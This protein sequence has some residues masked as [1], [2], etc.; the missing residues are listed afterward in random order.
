MAE[1]LGSAVLTVSVDDGQLK[2]G[3]QAAERQA[4]ATGRA[5]EKAFTPSGK[6]V[7]TAANGLQYFIDT[8]GRARDTAGKFL[9]VAQQQAAGIENVGK[10]AKRASFDISGLG[11]ALAAIGIGAA[12]AGFLRGSVNAAVEL[13]SISK[14]LSNTLGPQ[15]AGQALSFT[16]G[17]S[18]QLGLSFKTLANS[19]GSFTAAA[20]AAN[21]PLGEQRELFS[22]VARAAQ[23][24]GLSN[25]EINGSLLALQQVAA[26]GTVQM[27]ELRGQLGERLPIAFGA[28]AKGLGITQQELIKLVE[29]GRLTASEFFPA[30]TK[31]LNELT[32][33][34]GGTATAAQNFQKLANAFDELQTSF[35][36]TLLPT[37]TEQ[38][39]NLTGAL[40]GLQIGIDAN[41]LGLGGLFGNLGLVPDAGIEAVASVRQLAEQYQ[42]TAEQ[43]R[44]LFFDAA[45]LEGLTLTSTGFL[46]DAKGLE[47]ALERLPQLAEE[48]RAKNKDVVTELKAQA[49]EAARVASEQRKSRDSVENIQDAIKALSSEQKILAVD[50]SRFTEIGFEVEALKD[51]LERLQRTPLNF[52]SVAGLKQQLSDL[53]N[54]QTRLSVDSSAFATA[55]QQILETQ[56]ALEQLD[57]K[58]AII[59]VEQINAGVQDGSLTNNFSNLEKRSQ[60]A[61]QALNSA[62]FGSP[63]FQRALRAAQ[64]ANFELDQR[65]K[66][67][68]PAAFSKALEDAKK[69]QEDAAQ[70]IK[71]AFGKAEQAADSLTQAQ[72]SFRSALEGSFD[73][74]TSSRQN[75]L[76]NAS[77][78]DLQRAVN[79]GF[80]DSGKVAKLT[81]KELV[82]AAAQA[83]AVIDASDKLN[84]S[85]S[86]LINS[87]IALEKATANLVQKNWAVNVAVNAGTGDYAVNLG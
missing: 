84:G 45:K 20:T 50:S 2:A 22:A 31:G 1:S 25:D 6:S 21:V 56:N 66:A 34:A 55:N 15:G 41:K 14:K 76:L 71:D 65:R 51:R 70:G 68:D 19:F 49:A 16:K 38:V 67:A 83:R 23:A 54:Q 33:G 39:K 28:T 27:E 17:L 63:D 48:F 59:T 13:E 52:N 60:A 11:D 37:I 43:A 42:L 30:L 74:L 47:R 64:E 8:Q 61:Q 79:A 81:D 29:S 82:G 5:V 72:N 77:R 44:A 80:F 9:T 58:K 7:Q 12:A 69:A 86:N 78:N 75:D 3:L 40:N 10:S 26:K 57:G 18:D 36:N 73:L 32:E 87:N 4:V 85:Q 53:E 46:P 35:G 24:L 62:A